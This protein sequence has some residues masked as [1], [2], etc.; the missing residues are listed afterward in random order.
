MP[1]KLLAFLE[2][3]AYVL[4]F[5]L[6][7]RTKLKRRLWGC[8]RCFKIRTGPAGRPG[9]WST[10]LNPGETWSIFVLPLPLLFLRAPRPGLSHLLP[11][12]QNSS[13]RSSIEIYT[14][15]LLLTSIHYNPSS[16]ISLLHH[17]WRRNPLL[18]FS[19]ILALPS[20]PSSPSS[21]ASQSF[22]HQH[23]LPTLPSL[24]S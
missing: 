22:V 6:C 5:T 18:L 19:P 7:T 21:Y 9:T 1:L 16:P 20:T 8:T 2:D 17:Q 11:K 4:F 14:L 3:P 15:H 12:E 23:Q 10:W 13:W 24:T